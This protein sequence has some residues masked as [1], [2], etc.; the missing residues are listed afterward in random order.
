M[1]GFTFLLLRVLTPCF[2]VSYLIGCDV[3][4]PGQETT[5]PSSGRQITNL[6]P[7]SAPFVYTVPSQETPWPIYNGS[8][9][10]DKMIGPAH[11]QESSFL[12]LEVRKDYGA[13]IQIYDKVTKQN[14]INFRDQGRESGMGSYGGP[15]DFADDSPNWKGIGYNPLQAG[16]DGG[17]PSIMLFHGVINGWIY[18]KAQCLSW[19][20]KDARKLPF[21]YEQWVRLD[22]NK[23]H[24]KVRLTHQR[25]D[26]TFYEPEAQEWPFMFVNGARRVLFY[27]GS[28]P[29]TYDKTT[30]N[31]G[32]ESESTKN[33]VYRGTPYGVTE[34]WQAVEIAPN[35]YIGIYSPD[36]FQVN[37]HVDNIAANESWEGGNTITY[38]AHAPVV[39]LDSDNVWYKEYTYIVGTEQEIRDYVYAQPRS[40]KPDFFFNAF[41]GRSG[42]YIFDGG[43]DQKEPFTTDNWQVTLTGKKQNAYNA[44][45][46]SPYGNWKASD[47]NEVYLRM[48]YTGAP[49]A[50]AQVPLRLTWLIN[51]QAAEGVDPTHPV[52]SGVRFPDGSR[53]RSEQSLPFMAIND[54]K[55]HTY[56]FSFANQPKWTGVIQQFEVAHPFVP[57]YVTPGEKMTLQYF[58]V[59][60]PGN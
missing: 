23:V 56:K 59:R 38:V 31:D 24:V 35:R 6:P 30:L 19:A 1:P 16:D 36:Y 53:N 9:I 11:V 52:Q 37:F 44:K 54:G 17:N 22:E 48:A 43:Y 45:I 2:L 18:T 47:F 10:F 55:F 60:N 4:L 8:P 26:K 41:N 46:S 49:G 57:T 21:F 3:N 32:I 25:A 7:I 50:G 12:N 27:H 42:W 39:H 15:R 14:L 58:G 51:R 29:Y 5:S 28:S 33:I 40:P 20:H 13:S 34:P